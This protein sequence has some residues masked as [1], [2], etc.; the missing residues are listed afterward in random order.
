M[1]H[2]TQKKGAVVTLL[3]RDII[4]SQNARAGVPGETRWRRPQ[5]PLNREPR[6]LIEK[7]TTPRDHGGLAPVNGTSRTRRSPAVNRS[8]ESIELLDQL[9]RMARNEHAALA[10]TSDLMG[11]VVFSLAVRMLRDRPAAEDV[12]Q[13]I[14]VQVW[15][16]A[17]NYD[18][19]RGSPEA[20]IM[21]IARTRIL[22]R[23]RSR[24][25][26]VVLK[27]VGD[28]LPDAPD[29]E[30]WPEDLAITR[31]NAVNVR[32]ALSELPNDQKHA[33]ELAFFDGLTH[34][35]ISEKLN[36]P[37][38]T[39]KTRIRLGL[40][41]IRDRLRELMGEADATTVESGEVSPE[42]L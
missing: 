28:N 30:D 32:M 31:E 39:I 20:W 3:D 19:S 13:D 14:F 6:P 1:T 35:E 4:V 17:G 34:V 26:G 8:P 38:G 37:L 29:A 12:T 22:D 21:M 16:Q 2:E 15:R 9:H 41:K 23:L 42:T 18:T 33:I 5:A 27:P 7:T 25:A 10:R 11:P 36:V 40:M 24:A